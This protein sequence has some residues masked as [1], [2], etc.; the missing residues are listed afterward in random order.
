MCRRYWSDKTYHRISPDLV[1]VIRPN[2][3]GV[4]VA[5]CWYV[6]LD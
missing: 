2:Q 4:I 3:L 5:R 6:V 1:Q